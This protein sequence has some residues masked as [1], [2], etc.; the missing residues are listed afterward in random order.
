MAAAQDEV[1]LRASLGERGF[2]YSRVV[3]D[4]ML[5]SLRSG[6]TV[7]LEPCTALHP[8]DIVTIALGGSL[9]THRIRSCDRTDVVCRGDNR[10]SSDPP[11]DRAAV[12][13]RVTQVVGR[14]VPD[15]TRDVLRVRWHHHRL[16]LTGRLMRV[17]D[18]STLIFGSVV[19][20]SLGAPV[21]VSGDGFIG[22]PPGDPLE[23]VAQPQDLSN[24]ESLLT[25][26]S[27]VILVV[28]ASL[29]GGLSAVR[30]REL[31]QNLRGR[32]APRVRPA[33]GVCRPHHPP[34]IARSQASSGA[35]A[36][37]RGAGGHGRTRCRRPA[38]DPHVRGPRA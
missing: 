24:L 28:P 33:G 3:G 35:R 1:A 2:A 8:G 23:H 16:G 6:D 26:D 19:G 22:G 20:R 13:A 36:E 17:R 15:R 34:R 9:V 30:R 25:Q 7:L 27:D 31:M 5:P 11:V 18:E 38:R 21:A 29:Y 10:L 4:S 12:I 14:R 32:R 37:S